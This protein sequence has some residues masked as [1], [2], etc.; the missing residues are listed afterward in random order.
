MAQAVQVKKEGDCLAGEGYQYVN[1]GRQEYDIPDAVS[2][3]VSL[4]G[5]G[6]IEKSH[7]K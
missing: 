1:V 2:E 3:Q 6:H 5:V 4:A 7:G